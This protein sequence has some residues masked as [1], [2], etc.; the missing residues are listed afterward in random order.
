MKIEQFVETISAKPPFWG[1][2]WLFFFLLINGAEGRELIRD[3][4]E[5]VNETMK[6]AD[7]LHE[8]ANL[9]LEQT[10]PTTVFMPTLL[11]PLT[12]TSVWDRID[13]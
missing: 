13:P 4:R 12:K 5:K 9:L 1:K 8:K 11:L 3:L 6:S 7:R 2:V 10:R